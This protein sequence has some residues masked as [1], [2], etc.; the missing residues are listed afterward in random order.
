MRFAQVRPERIGIFCVQFDVASLNATALSR[1][2]LISS[3]DRLSKSSK[4]RLVQ[5]AG[6]GLVGIEPIHLL[7]IS[8]IAGGLGTPLTLGLML[9]VAR[10]RQVMAIGVE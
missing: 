9:W 6:I 4:C 5:A 10:D 1:M 8:S 7:Y 2:I 3:A